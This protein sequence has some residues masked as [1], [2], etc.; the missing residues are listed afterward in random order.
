MEAC[1]DYKYL[2]GYG[3]IQTGDGTNIFTKSQLMQIP[4]FKTQEMEV[5][6]RKVS[7][8]I[9][10]VD[11]YLGTNIELYI[12]SRL[13][14]SGYWIDRKDFESDRAIKQYLQ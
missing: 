10:D 4:N 3:F 12:D 8:H 11:D 5:L 1:I 14:F 2:Y 9:H 7:F 6:E 13:Q